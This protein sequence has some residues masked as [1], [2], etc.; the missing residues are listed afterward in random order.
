[1]RG[2][3]ERGIRP[4][5]AVIV[6]RPL[7]FQPGRI[8]VH[9]KLLD[10]ARIRQG[11][12]TT[13]IG[14]TRS[15]IAIDPIGST[16]APPA[17]VRRYTREIMISADKKLIDPGTIVV[18]IQRIVSLRRH[19]QKALM[20]GAEDHTGDKS[21]DNNYALHKMLFLRGVNYKLRSTPN[22]IFR[23]CGYCVP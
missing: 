22:S 9:L 7:V 23:L 12:R 13:R 18:G 2:R 17:A 1:M 10:G 5:D 21:E 19:S 20:T 4:G 14:I 11:A 6:R 16:G 3:D 15:K 8:G